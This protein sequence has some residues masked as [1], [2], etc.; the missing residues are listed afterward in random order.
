MRQFLSLRLIA[1]VIWTVLLPPER[2]LAQQ[3]Y[4]RLDKPQLP[5]QLLDY[6]GL[7]APDNIRALSS[8]AKLPPDNPPSDAGATLGRVLFYDRQL[9]KNGLVACGTCHT[10][11]FGFGDHTRFS[12]GFQGLITRRTAMPLANAGINPRGRYFRDERAINLEEQ[13][14]QPITDPVEM[15]L[16]PGEAV[17]R[18]EA[19]S[20][21][22]D[23]FQAAFGDR[24]VTDARIS[25]ALAQFVRSLVSRTS[26]YDRAKSRSADNRTL[27][28]PF[29]GFSTLENRGKFI[30]FAS[31]A[32]GGAGCAN[33]H[34]TDAFIMPRPRN[35]GL[36]TA[37]ESTDNG[38]GEITRRAADMGLFRTSSL[39]NI[40][41]SAPYMHDG[42]FATLDEVVEH[43]SIGIRSHPNLS[44]EL[45]ND[46]GSP[47]QFGFSE[48]DKAA[49]I[50]FLR[51]L[52]DEEMLS[53]ERFSDPF[54]KPKD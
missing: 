50:A 42:R 41:L 39:K 53:A 43:Y 21:Y 7:A 17:D 15:G 18:I 40:A 31:R 44:P 47:V 6:F 27:L 30:F 38:V 28:E 36:D 2:V 20:W 19:R 46:D 29:S 11:T 9:S 13:V 26:P 51:T 3:V 4:E 33:C 37:I 8:L 10:Q 48:T 12:I 49:L 32:D 45:Q 1:A 34:E 54:I 25:K 5:N 52:T 16:S 35:N 24:R 14:L 22:F 23:L